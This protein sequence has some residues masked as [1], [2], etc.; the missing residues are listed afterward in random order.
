MPAASPETLDGRRSRSERSRAAILDAALALIR[1]GNLLPTA[2]QIT[3]RAGVG[4]RTFFRHFE[5]METLFRAVD[6]RTHET[7]ARL[8][9]VDVPS[10]TLSERIECAVRY[11]GAAYEETKSVFLSSQ[12]LIWRSDV[13][14]EVY[15]RDRRRLRR[16]LDEW[17]PEVAAL[18]HRKREA[19]DAVASIEFWVRLRV[20]QGLGTEESIE[21]V[22]G[23]IM[24][25]IDTGR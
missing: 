20:R 22:S 23:L 24:G 1:E 12:A 9:A 21:I 14:A 15:E 2:Q 13:L 4:T 25:L 5:D 6:E 10:G 16:K 11:F 3:A 7:V 19:V 17:L 18:P 8:F